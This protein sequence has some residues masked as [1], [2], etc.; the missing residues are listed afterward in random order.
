MFFQG[1]ACNDDLCNIS[2]STTQ[3]NGKGGFKGKKSN[4]S[5]GNVPSL[6][7]AVFQIYFFFFAL[8][9]IIKYF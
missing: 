7:A 2:P 6:T 1:Y 4:A 3:I 5:N 8:N 9:N